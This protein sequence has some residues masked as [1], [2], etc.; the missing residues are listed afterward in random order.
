MID[1]DKYTTVSI[2]GDDLAIELDVNDPF[3]FGEYRIDDMYKESYIEEKKKL[4][5]ELLLN[6]SPIADEYEAEEYKKFIYFVVDS[7]YERQ[8]TH[9]LKSL[10]DLLYPFLIELDHMDVENLKRVLPNEDPEDDTLKEII[11]EFAEEGN[12]FYDIYV[13]ILYTACGKSIAYFDKDGLTQQRT[14]PIR[15]SDSKDDSSNRL[16]TEQF[17]YNN[18]SNDSNDSKTDEDEMTQEEIEEDFNDEDSIWDD[19]EPYEDLDEMVFNEDDEEQKIRRNMFTIGSQVE[20]EMS[21]HEGYMDF[22]NHITEAIC[23]VP[24]GEGEYNVYD[25]QE[26]LNKYLK[27]NIM[28]NQRLK[29][30]L[31]QY[32]TIYTAV[33]KWYLDRMIR[34]II[35][36]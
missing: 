25:I 14:S 34:K 26:D 29:Q 2:G 8:Q 16:G 17:R 22:L 1:T 7:L 21:A 20:R 3:L 5:T 32:P 30:I 23:D 6:V 33:Y 10:F 27:L 4:H 11:K 12:T 15:E 24:E 28:A 35:K 36:S 19:V 9:T 13:C 31:D 18:D